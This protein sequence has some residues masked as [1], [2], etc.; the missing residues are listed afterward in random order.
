MTKVVFEYDPISTRW[1]PYV[2]GAQDSMEA[3][4][5]FSAVVL[6][7]QMLEPDLLPMTIAKTGRHKDRYN[8]TPAVGNFMEDGLEVRLRK[9]MLHKAWQAVL[10]AEK[11]GGLEARDW[12]KIAYD[13]IQADSKEVFP[14]ED[15]DGII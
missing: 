2:E 10:Q 7:C 1:S 3:R 13:L 12:A 15:W 6:T 5:G 14:E 4:H 9:Q 8:I 11:F